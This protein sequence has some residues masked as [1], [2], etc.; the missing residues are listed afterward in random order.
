MFYSNQVPA[1]PLTS[2]MASRGGGG[3]CGRR[4]CRQCHSHRVLKQIE[5]ISDQ[6]TFNFR[7]LGPLLQQWRF[8]FDDPTIIPA[9]FQNIGTG[10]FLHQIGRSFVLCHQADCLERCPG[11]EEL[12]YS[13]QMEE[14]LETLLGRF[15]V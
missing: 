12:T 3:S 6:R 14:I 4:A 9:C 7:H 5:E 2:C 13:S 1:Q 10:G 15:F 11:S 8:L